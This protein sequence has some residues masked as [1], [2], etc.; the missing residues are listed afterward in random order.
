MSGFLVALA[1]SF[2][3]YLVRPA[4]GAPE[5][6]NLFDALAS[7]DGRWYNEIA[8]EGYRYDPPS[9]S[10][11]AFFP[12]YPCLGRAVIAIT[13][14]PV[15]IAL[16]IVSNVSLLG[17]LALLGLY[18]SARYANEGA[19]VGEWTMLSAVDRGLEGDHF[20]G[21]KRASYRAA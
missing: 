8:A 18:A 6:R 7:M 19:D 14:F 15:C 20:R 5:N 10:N 3:F 12:V 16:L 17:A 1:F 11:I 4:P 13:G 9:R 2:G 21:P